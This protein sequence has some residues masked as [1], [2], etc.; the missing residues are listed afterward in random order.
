MVAVDT[1]FELERKELEWLLSAGVMR[2]LL[3]VAAEG[4]WSR[5]WEAGGSWQD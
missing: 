4:Q 5:S 2:L 3:G 1:K